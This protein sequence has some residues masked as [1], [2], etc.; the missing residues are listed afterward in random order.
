MIIDKGLDN[1]TV[2]F[3]RCKIFTQEIPKTITQTT[4]VLPQDPQTNTANRFNATLS[5]K[6]TKLEMV[7][8]KNSEEKI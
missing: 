6:T 4:S 5:L 8:K 3:Y 7:Q 1:W 2:K